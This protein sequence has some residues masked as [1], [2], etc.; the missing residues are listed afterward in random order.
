MRQSR[1]YFFAGI[2]KE[3]LDQRPELSG[4]RVM[5]DEASGHIEPKLGAKLA[6]DQLRPHLL[7]APVGNSLE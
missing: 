5:R 4:C 1:V 3:E 7:D 2:A 6:G